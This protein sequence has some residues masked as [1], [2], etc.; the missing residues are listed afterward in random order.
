[1]LEYAFSLYRRGCI[2]ESLAAYDAFLSE[3]PAHAEALHLSGLALYAK[4]RPSEAA[5]RIERSLQVDGSRVEAWCNLALVYQA[6]GRRTATIAALRE[7][8]RRD[9]RQ[10]E[11]WSNLAG[12][13]LETGDAVDAENA[14]RR[15]LVLEPR[16]VASH[17]NLALPSRRKTDSRR[18]SPSPATFWMWYPRTSPRP[19]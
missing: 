1:M 2:D 11:I 13:L 9:D 8:L 18:R 16:H 17:Y 10:P 4:D 19:V 3:W 5:S 14:A 6:L 7:A 15:A 12:V